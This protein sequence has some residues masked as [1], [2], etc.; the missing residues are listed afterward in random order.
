MPPSPEWEEHDFDYKGTALRHVKNGEEEYKDTYPLY[1]AISDASKPRWDLARNGGSQIFRIG[2]INMLPYDI[3]Y[4]GGDYVVTWEQAL[5]PPRQQIE[6][7]Y[8]TR[9]EF[10]DSV[11][12]FRTRPNDDQDPAYTKTIVV[13][14]GRSPNAR[15]LN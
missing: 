3:D 1:F 6:S 13:P 8:Q 5:S 10:R 4:R 2:R 7:T 14:Y 12:Y 11:I 15:L 9:V